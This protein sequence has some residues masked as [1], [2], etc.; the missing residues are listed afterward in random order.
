[1]ARPR[2]FFLEEVEG[3]FAELDTLAG[4]TGVFELLTSAREGEAT[5]TKYEAKIAPTKH[6]EKVRPSLETTSL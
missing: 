5:A 1:V 2:Y 4:F 6:L 3:A